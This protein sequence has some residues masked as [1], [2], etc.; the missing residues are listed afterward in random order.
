MNLDDVIKKCKETKSF[1]LTLTIRDK[2]KEEDNLN[3]YIIQHDFPVDDIINSVDESLRSM[4][5][6]TGT[7]AKVIKSELK[8]EIRKLKIAILSHCSKMPTSYSPGNAIKAQVKMLIKFGH[9]VVFFTQEGSK[10]E[11]EDIGC[12]VRHLVPRFKREKNVINEDA[13]NKMTDMLRRE[14]TSDFDVI[15]TQDFYID[16][17][18]TYREALKECN[19]NKPILNFCRSG[20]GRPINFKINN[21]KTRYVYLN[22]ADSKIFA[23]K[24]GVDHSL[25]R[26][27]FN[28]K[29]PEWFFNFS[30]TTKMIIDKMKLYDKQIIQTY[31]ICT[32]RMDAKQLNIVIRIF[33]LLKEMGYKVALII[34]N[35]NGRKR[36]NE[37]DAKIKFALDCGLIEGEDIIFTSKLHNERF[38]L[39]NEIPNNV[40]AELTQISNLFVFPTSAEVCSN[41]LLENSIASN[42][43][44]VNSDLPALLDFVDNNSVL[45]YPFTSFGNLHYKRRDD[46]S[47]KKLC[48]DIVGQLM[49]NKN[50]LQFRYVWKRHNAS[51]IYKMLKDILFE[52]I[53][54]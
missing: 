13:K 27:V 22:E 37:I 18:I 45:K 5:K 53:D 32:T 10:L 38:N 34:C 6:I 16:D 3:H 11:T 29:S 33:G 42:L 2:D 47:L 20:I 39:E 30:D 15:I 25:I 19:I 24:I 26:V 4:K 31:A 35:S 36:I 8:E 48:K 1:F 44:V 51:A 12:E 7:P 41:I 23:E 43:I 21:D 54:N 52:N 14:I 40:V 28:E 46:E 50:D 49:S 9:E 17:C